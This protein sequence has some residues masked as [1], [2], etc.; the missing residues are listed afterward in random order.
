M[1]VTLNHKPDGRDCYY[2]LP[3]DISYSEIYVNTASPALLQNKSASIIQYAFAHELGHALGLGDIS[4][5]GSILMNPD[6]TYTAGGLYDHP[7]Y[8]NIGPTFAETGNEPPCSAPPR[9]VNCIYNW[10]G[11]PSPASDVQ[12]PNDTATTMPWSWRAPPTVDKDPIPTYYN[13]ASWQYGGPCNCWNYASLG[14]QLAWAQ[15]GLTNGTHYALEVAAC[16]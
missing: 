14:N 13:V 12:D 9:G 6:W 15:T 3:C 7:A 11:S 5:G 8:T 4:G 1:G 2:G 10:T 16:N